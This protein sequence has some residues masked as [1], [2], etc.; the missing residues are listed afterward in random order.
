MFDKSKYQPGNGAPRPNIFGLQNPQLTPHRDQVNIKSG[1]EINEQIMLDAQDD[2]RELPN[3]HNQSKI[4]AISSI[5]KQ[6]VKSPVAF[7]E[8]PLASEQDIEDSLSKS[9]EKSREVTMSQLRT[10]Q[11]K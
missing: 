6:S 4:D 3:N 7:E 5:N 1:D 10:P 11:P 9:L 2:P 8:P